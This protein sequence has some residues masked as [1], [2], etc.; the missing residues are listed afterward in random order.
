MIARQPSAGRGGGSGGAAAGGCAPARLPG[1]GP[2]GAH[3]R[4]AGMTTLSWQ[5]NWERCP[6]RAGLPLPVR[7]AI[8]YPP[9]IAASWVPGPRARSAPESP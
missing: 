9:S 4:P 3:L 2:T 7:G 1:A 8:A 5:G 6:I